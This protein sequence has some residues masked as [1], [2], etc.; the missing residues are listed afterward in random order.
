MFSGENVLSSQQIDD[1]AAI[2]HKIEA[3][4]PPI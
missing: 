2:E 1:P 4:I 3:L